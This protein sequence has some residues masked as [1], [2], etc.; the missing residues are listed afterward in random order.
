MDGGPSELQKRRGTIDFIT[1]KVAAAL[2]KCKVSS[3]NVVHLVGVFAEAFNIDRDSLVL[4]KSSI[5]EKRKKKRE[6]R[7][8]IIKELVKKNHFQHLTLHWDS[9]QF[10][11]AAQKIVPKL[12]V[13]VS[14]VD[15]EYYLRHLLLKT[16]LEIHKLR[17]YLNYYKNM[18]SQTQL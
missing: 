7:A 6:E 8:R 4:N 11:S 9:K 10:P 17:P 13:V 14:D 1:T 18:E 16:K 3:R 5:H 15:L 2:D 12:A